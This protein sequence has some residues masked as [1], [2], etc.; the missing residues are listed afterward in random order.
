[1]LQQ[2]DLF[3]PPERVFLRAFK[4][5]RV[6]EI[7]GSNGVD[8]VFRKVTEMPFT[9]FSGELGPKRE[10]GDGQI[11]EGFYCIDNFNPVSQ[12]AHMSLHLNYPNRSDQ[13][14][15]AGTDPGG[16]ICIHGHWFSTGC[17]VIGDESISKLFLICLEAHNN[18]QEKI[19][20]HI[21][22]CKMPS[23][24]R[25][26]NLMLDSLSRRDSVLHAFWENLRTGY[27][28][29]ERSYRLP[30]VWIDEVGRYRFRL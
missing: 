2:T 24:C 13:I 7:W 1:M 26:N 15:K 18:G 19:S 28:L 14:F 25:E 6:L 29:F 8:S 10:R 22:P 11:P 16:D 4:S 20:V 30:E 9:G 3:Y 17:V 21:F 27:E 5:E 23:L 12:Y